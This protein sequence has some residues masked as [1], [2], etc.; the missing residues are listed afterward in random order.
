[1]L[2][3]VLIA[4]IISIL[5]AGF[6]TITAQ[7]PTAPIIK[8][9]YQPVQQGAETGPTLYLYKISD[10]RLGFPQFGYVWDVNSSTEVAQTTQQYESTFQISC[11]ATQNPANIASL[12]ASDLANYAAYIMQSAS[13]IASL[14]A[15]GVGIYRV[16]DVRNQNFVDDRD[17][18]EFAPNFDF[19]LTHK[20]IITLT[21]PIITETVI[22]ILDV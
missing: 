2:D 16:S 12:T 21:A 6:A 11:W 22:Q 20:Q 14:E 9:S 3:N 15:T 8:Q 10:I 4:Q 5:Q 1:M 19:T 17:R 18:F 13:T 7:V